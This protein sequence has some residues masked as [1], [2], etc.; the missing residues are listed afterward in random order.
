MNRRVCTLMPLVILGLALAS[1]SDAALVGWWKFD[2]GSDTVAKD[3]SG[4]GYHGTITNPLW[5][6][7]QYG[8][9]LNFEGD[10]YVDVPPESW[11]TIERQATVSFWA[12]GNPDLQPQANFIFGAFSDPADNEARRMCAH[13]PW[14]DGTIYFDTGGPS[15]NRINK[16]GSAADYEGTW[17]F[18]TFLKNADTG[19]QQV[20]INGELWHSGTGMTNTMEGVTKFTIGT[21]PSLA[22]GWYQGMIDDFRLYDHALTLDEI[23]LAMTGRGPGL[24]LASNPVPANEASDIPRD[25]VLS[26]DA[27]EYAASHD[28]YFGT[29]FDDV[30]TASRSNPMD[31]LLSQGQAGTTFDPPGILDFGVTYYWRIDEVNAAP[32]NTVFK[33]EVWSFAAEPLAYPMANV[34]A[35]S[36]GISDAGADPENTVNGSGLNPDDQHSTTSGDMWVAKP[37]EGESLWIQ[38]EFDRLYKLHQMIVWNYNVQFE[39][40]LGFGLKDVTVEYSQDGAEWTVLG[41]VQLN[42]AT[43]SATYTANTA[44]DFEGVAAKFVRLTVNSAWGGMGQY[45]LSEV[46]FMYIPV[47]AR[48]PQPAD[49]AVEVGV[50][51]ALAWRAG[52]DAVSHEVYLGT[53]AEA[54]APAGTVA[55]TSYT[56]SAMDL[57]TTYYWQVNAVQETESWDGVVWSFATQDYLVVDDFE[58]YTDDIDAGE[59]IFDTW[60][61]GWVNNTGSTV[62]HLNSPFAEQTIVHSGRQSMPLSYDNTGMTTAEAHYAL[63]ADWSA[64]G[65]RSL[66]LYF[67]GAEGNTG[68]LYVKING[69]KVAYDGPAVNLTRPGWQLWSIDLSQIGNISSVQSLTIG[70][71]GAGA[72]GVVYIDD[73]RLYPE[74][75]D[76][77]SPEITGAG[78]VVQGV[79]NDGDWPDAEYPALAIDDNVNTKYLHRKGG[80]QA[81]GFQVA[82]LLGSTVV[83]GLTFTTAN[84]APTRDPIT[85]QLSGSNAS[86]DGPYTLI[87]SGD[88]VDFAG[89]TEW[90]RLTKTVTPIEFANTTAYRYYEIVFPTLRG[91]AET[92]MQIAEVEFLGTVVP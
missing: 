64:H 9:A 31:L 17:T 66:S 25:V 51:S 65:I 60:L 24:E 67:Y 3:S 27:G 74:V 5:V 15:Y 33:G 80:S 16:A 28:V 39:L 2:D 7:G 48:E 57:A 53:D 10:S 73:V 47:Q 52:R 85:F 87:A 71:E 88:I 75:L 49:A 44:I 38:F 19:D 86:I 41:D 1:V 12:F 92:L 54:L 34:I 89:A 26:W 78:D 55:G 23:Q 76:Y 91:P 21:K 90:P 8:G 36:N 77:S 37:V 82:P 11:S 63:T 58:S 50:N 59:A 13:V 69:T 61:D 79:P 14:S 35:A 6:D 20:Y 4:K 30:N 70:V 46:R 68:Q 22:E 29:V 43:A 32:D 42:Q 40:L 62:G 84:D 72:N 18:W 56:P 83:T 81:T 45:G